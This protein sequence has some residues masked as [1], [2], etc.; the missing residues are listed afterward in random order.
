MTLPIPTEMTATVGQILTAA[1]WNSNVRD[2]VNFLANP[3]IFRGIQTVVQSVPNAAYTDITFDS[4]TV[5]SYGGHSISTNTARY[6]AQLA[7]WYFCTGEI[8]YVSNGTGRRLA[9]LFINGAQ[10][11]E[12]EAPAVAATSTHAVVAISD[13]QFLNVGDFVTLASFQSSTAALSTFVSAGHSQSFFDV[14]WVHA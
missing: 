8:V 2:G 4:E 9:G 7:G 14:L 1:Q 6:T 3:P 10:V 12:F 13:L 11:D 5:D